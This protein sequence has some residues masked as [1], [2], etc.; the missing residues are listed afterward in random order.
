MCGSRFNTDLG[1]SGGWRSGSASALGAEGRTF[2]SY[3]S[4]FW[5]V[6][7]ALKMYGLGL[8]FIT[9][10]ILQSTDL[11]LSALLLAGCFFT[12]AFWLAA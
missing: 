10:L 5:G 4:E 6:G 12:T 3:L 8:L 9:V 1:S 7:E 2:K 11:V